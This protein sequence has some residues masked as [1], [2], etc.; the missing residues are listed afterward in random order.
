[1]TVGTVRCRRC[2]LEITVGAASSSL[3]RHL[4]RATSVELF[5]KAGARP[6]FLT[7]VAQHRHG[8]A[9][10]T[11][12]AIA[13][14]SRSPHAGKL[15]NLFLVT[16]LTV[17]RRRLRGCFSKTTPFLLGNNNKTLKLTPPKLSLW[18]TKRGEKKVLR[19]ERCRSALLSRRRIRQG[20][21]T[22]RRCCSQSVLFM[23]IIRYFPFA[24]GDREP[25][26]HS[27]SQLGRLQKTEEAL[28]P[29]SPLLAA[30]FEKRGDAFCHSI[31]RADRFLFSFFFLL[32]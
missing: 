10:Q 13:S 15:L 25:S 9:H 8:R 11:I 7:C 22:S 1:M 6:R 27:R 24:S 29:S 32:R 17:S 20:D 28:E 31:S 19:Q 30:T 4:R 2:T 23:I 26:L 12:R 16:S 3:C 5:L 18:S 21:C 14:T